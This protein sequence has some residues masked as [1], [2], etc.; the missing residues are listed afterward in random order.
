MTKPSTDNMLIPPRASVLR[1]IR[2]PKIY[3]SWRSHQRLIRTAT[4]V[5]NSASWWHSVLLSEFGTPFLNGAQRSVN[6]KVQGSN[7]W[8]G[9]NCKFEIELL[10]GTACLPEA[11]LPLTCRSYLRYADVLT[12]ARAHAPA[13]GPRVCVDDEAPR[14]AGQQIGSG[15]WLGQARRRGMHRTFSPAL[16]NRC[17][18]TGSHRLV[19]FLG[20]P[21]TFSP[22]NYHRQDAL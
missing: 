1:R 17:S 11:N 2:P 15:L 8:S 22:R 12:T 7:P 19:S 3:E 5:P 9:A 18:A 13:A 20:L 10:T 6:R 14:S 16:W 4:P 21:H